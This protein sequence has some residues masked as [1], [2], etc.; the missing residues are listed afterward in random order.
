MYIESKKQ[1]KVIEESVSDLQEDLKSVFHQA[2]RM[3]KVT[4]LSFFSSRL[5]RRMRRQSS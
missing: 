2:H 1:H 4:K 5:R 3:T